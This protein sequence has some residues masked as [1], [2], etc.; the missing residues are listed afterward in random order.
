MRR[1]QLRHEFVEFIPSVQE[2]GV[3]YISI[4]F[5]TA[6]HRC[7]CGCGEKVVTPISPTDWKLTYDGRTVSLTPSIGSW[8]LKCQSHYWVRNNRVEWAPRMSR[9]RIDAGRRRARIAKQQHFNDDALS[10]P[11]PDQPSKDNP[12]RRVLDWITRRTT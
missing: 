5:A 10:S 7:C 11:S 8:G 4:E 9:D 3:L 6:V 12:V 1:N 2:D